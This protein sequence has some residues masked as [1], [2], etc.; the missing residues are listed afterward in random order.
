VFDDKSIE[1][2]VNG[3]TTNLD[4][5][6]NPFIVYE[7]GLYFDGTTRLS[8]D[9]LVLN[10][11]FT[12]EFVVRPSVPGGDMMHIPE[13]VLSAEIYNEKWGFQLDNQ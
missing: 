6:P 13:L 11:Q 10:T 5:D 4:T 12:L 2:K 9:N 1:Q 8:L 7:R 3:V